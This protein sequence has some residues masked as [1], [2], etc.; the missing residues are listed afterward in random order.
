[1]FFCCFQLRVCEIISLYAHVWHTHIH[2]HTRTLSQLN[3]GT[4]YSDWYRTSRRNA[5][6]TRQIL[7]CC[8]Y[9]TLRYPCCV[10]VALNSD[11]LKIFWEIFLVLIF[12]VFLLH[13]ID[14]QQHLAKMSEILFSILSL[15]KFHVNF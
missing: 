1:M 6:N 11:E 3:Y 13:T 15:H 8:L 5:L 10:C 12:Y 7:N 2:V 4:L 14:L 9:V